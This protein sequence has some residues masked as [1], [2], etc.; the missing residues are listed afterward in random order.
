MALFGGANTVDE[1]KGLKVLLVNFAAG[2]LF[3]KH[4]YLLAVSF[5]PWQYHKDT[6]T[7]YIVPHQYILLTSQLTKFIENNYLFRYNLSVITKDWN[8]FMLKYKAICWCLY[9][10]DIV[11]HVAIQLDITKY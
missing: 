10:C 6:P 3:F 2:G 7:K 1:Y 8:G 5:I 4:R 9:V 11:M